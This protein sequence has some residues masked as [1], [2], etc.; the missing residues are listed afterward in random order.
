MITGI[1]CN[2]MELQLFDEDK[3][4]VVSQLDDERMLGYYSPQNNWR[5]H[6]CIYN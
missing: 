2:W 3:T 6:V 1:M 4:L 5:I